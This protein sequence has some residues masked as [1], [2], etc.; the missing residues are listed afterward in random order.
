[1]AKAKKN[2]GSYS[3]M[4]Q[5]KDHAAYDKARIE[6]IALRQSKDYASTETTGKFHSPNTR[7]VGKT[8]NGKGYKNLAHKQESK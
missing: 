4:D 3:V 2:Q 7:N 8:D 6:K 5:A 1:M